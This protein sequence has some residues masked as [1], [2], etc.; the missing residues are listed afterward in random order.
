[1]AIFS[2]N[3]QSP[4]TNFSSNEITTIAKGTTFV[5]DI[6]A[7]SNIH[8]DGFIKGN[9]KSN[10]VI[11]IGEQ[12]NFE[13]SIIA[14]KVIIG[15]SFNGEINAEYVEL[16]SKC[17]VKGEIYNNKLVIE[18]GA[19]FEGASKRKIQDSKKEISLNMKN[20]KIEEK[21]KKGS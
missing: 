13:G 21:E 8:I 3:N 19:E 20:Q 11:T 17:S 16:A 6:D 7:T 4:S 15:G 9:I 5:G 18:E 1:M 14:E 12:G 2:K 10:S